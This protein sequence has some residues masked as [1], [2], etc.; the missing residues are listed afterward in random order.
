MLCFEVRVNGKLACTAGAGK[1][2]VMVAGVTWVKS[3]RKNCPELQSKAEWCREDLG[4]QVSGIAGNRGHVHWLQ[5]D[6]QL[7]DEVSI[8]VVQRPRGDPPAYRAEGE[9]C[10]GRH[11]FEEPN[12]AEVAMR[13]RKR[14]RAS[15]QYYEVHLSE[16]IGG[17]D[18][19]DDCVDVEVVFEDRVR[20]IGTFFKHPPKRKGRKASKFWASEDMILVPKLTKKAIIDAVATLIAQGNLDRAFRRVRDGAGQAKRNRRR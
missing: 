12:Q 15:R 8:R 18:P 13:V 10:E 6:L 7:G 17:V 16:V 9:L 2:G 19:L 14:D 20:Y 4:L 3:N 11:T 5:Q 1:Q